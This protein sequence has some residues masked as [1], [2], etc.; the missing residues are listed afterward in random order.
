MMLVR[1]PIGEIIE[2]ETLGDN[3]ALSIDEIATLLE[4]ESASVGLLTRRIAEYDVLI[5]ELVEKK[6]LYDNGDAEA[7]QSQIDQYEAE[8]VSSREQKTTTQARVTLYNS[9][10]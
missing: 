2:V 6:S 3:T 10:L 4:Q 7:I 5:S 8:K 1:T 9:Y